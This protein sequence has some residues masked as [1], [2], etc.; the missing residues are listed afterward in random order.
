MARAASPISPVASRRSLAWKPRSL[1]HCVSQDNF[2]CSKSSAIAD[3]LGDRRCV[4]VLR[5]LTCRQGSAY[6]RLSYT[7]GGRLCLGS[8]SVPHVQLPSQHFP[9]Q[10][11]RLPILPTSVHVRLLNVKTF[12]MPISGIRTRMQP[13]VQVPTPE[14]W[15]MVSQRRA[16]VAKTCHNTALP[17]GHQ[18]CGVQSQETLAELYNMGRVRQCRR[19]STAVCQTCRAKSRPSEPT[20]QQISNK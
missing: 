4:V 5:H 7:A 19:A 15:E 11:R 10:E 16:W 1:L 13:V 9:D 2:G 14:R 8:G 20:S 12:M 18:K 3:S 6:R 17:R